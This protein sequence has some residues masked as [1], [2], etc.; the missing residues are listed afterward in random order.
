MIYAYTIHLVV[1]A[2]GEIDEHVSYAN[3]KQKYR[4]PAR[5]N[6]H[7]KNAHQLGGILTPSLVVSMRLECRVSSQTPYAVELLPQLTAE[8]IALQR[9][10]S[11][12][13]Q[14]E[15]TWTLARCEYHA[16]WLLL[17]WHVV[18]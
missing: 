7:N 15:R 8:A 14:I 10:Q 13:H 5:R 4:D 9:W 1:S 11:A 3:K 12:P 17:N 16:A 6:L 18:G 2:L